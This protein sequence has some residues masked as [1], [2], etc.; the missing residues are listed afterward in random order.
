MTRTCDYCGAE[1]TAVG[2]L[3]RT[4]SD[5]CEQNKCAADGCL[6]CASDDDLAREDAYLAGVH[7]PCPL[8]GYAKWAGSGHPWAGKRTPP[9]TRWCVGPRADA[10]RRAG[11][12][13]AA[14]KGGASC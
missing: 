1:F 13:P 2:D 8:C 5:D 12:T 11:T 10:D 7:K 3:T 6:S 14:P 9:K 4:C